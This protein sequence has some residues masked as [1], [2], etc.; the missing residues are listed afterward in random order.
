MLNH[1]NEAVCQPMIDINAESREIM[2]YSD[3]S[4]NGNLG[5]GAVFEDNWMYSKWERD[6]IKCLKPSI[7]YLELFAIAAA[8]LTWGD[9]IKHK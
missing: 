2:F 8:L 3:A 9:L 4:T 7:E 1:K 5:F 6:Y